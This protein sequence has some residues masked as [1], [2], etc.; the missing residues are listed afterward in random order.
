[1]EVPGFEFVFV[2]RIEDASSIAVCRA[3][4]HTFAMRVHDTGWVD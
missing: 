4:G 1:M 3:A 2:R